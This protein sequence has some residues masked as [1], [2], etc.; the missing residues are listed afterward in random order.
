MRRNIGVAIGQQLSP[1][2]EGMDLNSIIHQI[3]LED[4]LVNHVDLNR[5][6]ATIDI[7]EALSRV[8]LD[9]LLL[10]VDIDGLLERSNLEAIIS[11]SSLG[12]CTSC[13]NTLRSKLAYLDQSIQ[14][15]GRLSC[16][17]KEPWL[18]PIPGR[19]PDSRSAREPWP[20][21]SSGGAFGK[22]IQYRCCGTLTRWL[23]GFIDWALFTGVFALV[24][25]LVRM[26]VEAVSD[27]ES[28]NWNDYIFR[29]IVPSIYLILFISWQLLCIACLGKT[30]GMGIIGLLLVSKG[31]HRVGICQAL[32]RILV[33][34]PLLNVGLMMMILAFRTLIVVL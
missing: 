18:P 7:D 30:V 17:S 8:D 16:C 11:R 13:M 20:K 34:C 10:R 3:D 9:S 1:V 12:F 31:G 15:C 26:I 33:R 22:A 25:W 5:V 24:S 32:I 19:S 28:D 21:Q 4:L 29:Y 23:S 14:R 27:L 2:V 6:L